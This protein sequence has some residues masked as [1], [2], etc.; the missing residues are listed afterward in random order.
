MAARLRLALASARLN[1]SSSSSSICDDDDEEMQSDGCVEVEAED[2]EFIVSPLFARLLVPSSAEQAAE[3]TTS[4]SASASELSIPYAAADDEE[5]GGNYYS[6]P[7][8]SG[9]EEEDEESQL[10]SVTLDP[11]LQMTV[12]VN[13]NA[14]RNEHFAAGSTTR[15]LRFD[16]AGLSILTFSNILVNRLVYAGFGLE[17]QHK[18]NLG[19]KIDWFKSFY[20]VEPSTLLPCFTDLKDDYPDIY[21]KNCLLTMNW[22]Y[23]YDTYPVLSGR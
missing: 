17:R 2:R 3:S 6:S 23:L 11:L 7:S 8:D 18:N 4:A 20:G 5:E 10:S 9:G 13:V 19:R 12:D 15:H 14:H 22:F 1:F 16:N 21:Y